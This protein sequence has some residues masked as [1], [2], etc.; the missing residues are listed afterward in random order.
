M[1]FHCRVNFTCVNKLE[2]MYKRS[3]VDVKVEPGMHVKMKRKCK[4]T[5][6]DEKPPINTHGRS[7]KEISIL[8]AR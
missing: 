4:S 5:L 8:V 3:R 6:R 1:D 2:V 7:C